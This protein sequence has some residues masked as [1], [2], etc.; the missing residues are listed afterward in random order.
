M[1]RVDRC[2]GFGGLGDCF[3]I[4]LKLL[5]YTEPLIY[6]HI[7]TS[8]SRLQLSMQLLDMFNIDHDCF[9]VQNIQQ[10]WYAN[11]TQFD[12]CFNVFAK[13]F[14]DIPRRS[15]HWDPCIDDGYHDPFTESEEQ[16]SDCVV[17]QVSSGGQR[18]YKYKP[19]V[20]YVSKNYDKDKIVWIGTDTDFKIDYG[21]NY[22]GELSFIQALG[23]VATS[24]YFVGFPSVLLYWA[25]WYKRPCYL[26]TDHQGKDDLRIH[27][28]WKSYIT[29]DVDNIN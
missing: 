7:D 25:L 26:F 23:A 18:S 8:N 5:E 21:T 11:Y 13:G 10:W 16:R 27:D 15:Y 14:I 24:K 17:V 9:V 28:A 2:L 22:C 20:E 29:Y 6:T 12:K 1:E 3:I 4:I 19:V